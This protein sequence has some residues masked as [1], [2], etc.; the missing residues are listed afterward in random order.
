MKFISKKY[1]FLFLFLN[2]VS[3]I[4]FSQV[5]PG[6]EDDAD[7]VQNQNLEMLS[8]N[9]QSE[10][11]DFT[12]LV[13]QLKYF[14]AHPINLNNTTKDELLSLGLLTELQ[15]ISLLEHIEKNG[16]FMTI[17]ELQSVNG[18]DI[19]TIRKILPFVEVSDNFKSA[20]F[21]FKEMMKNG[22]H[23]VVSRLQR[24]LEDQSG[25]KPRPSDDSINFNT[26][27][28]FYLG[29]AN[30]IFTRY[31]FTYGNNVSLGFIGEKDAGEA[32]RKI[33]ALNKKAGFDFYTAHFF[34]R[35]VKWIKA[36]AVGDYQASFGQGLV[37]W[38]GFGF[39]KNAV[40]TS[41][42][43]NA[44]G[45]NQYN[46]VDENR[47]LRGAA[48]TFNVGK[49]LEATAIFSRKKVDAN[50]TVATDTIGNNLFD[51]E[52]ISS[53]ITGGIHSTVNGLEDKNKITET[54]YGG[55]LTYKGKR[56]NV[57]TTMLS[58][59]LDAEIKKNPSI[60][61]QFD[62][63]GKNNLNAGVDFSYIYRNIN[64]YGEGAVSKNGGKAIV[65][66]ALCAL[67]PRFNFVA[68]YRNFDKDYQNLVA[69]AISENTLPQ[70][71]NGLYMGFEAKLPGNITFTS[72][73]DRFKFPWLKST[74]TGSSDGFDFFSQLNWT[75][76]KKVDMYLR[77]RSRNRQENTS[78]DNVFDYLA[79]YN[80]QNFRYNVTFSVIPS[81]RLRTRIE[82]VRIKKETEKDE[83]GFV[84]FQDVVWKKLGWPL[85]VTA[86]YGIFET[87]SY[88]S[89]IY[90]YENDVLYSFSVPALYNKGQ[91]AYLIINY[92][93]T[94][95][96]EIW[97]RFAQTF[98]TNQNIQSPGD[99]LTEIIGPAKSE[100]KIQLRIKL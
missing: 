85:T 3:T 14:S 49:R 52:E 96:F 81:L 80:Q 17:Y 34:I 11:A 21:G 18:F 30:R 8:E 60:Y 6:K 1:F 92:D 43:R 15:V 25:F 88:T 66:G 16:K 19:P 27:D 46:S 20:H 78:I 40:V 98:Y 55:N 67:D 69:S 74:A 87:D 77:A 13:E 57:G 33:P 90:T 91:R 35:N 48:F 86:R 64:L 82:A 68:Y 39:G 50:V 31:R 59:N 24:I 54:I 84:F 9:L 32:F 7:N 36:L 22:K 75:P 29:S 76:S 56:L 12:N 42:K 5:V 28:S 2:C 95:K 71:E 63:S 53:L 58:Y 73:F 47:F 41:V 38:R 26:P 4:C 100:I 99:R 61:N 70:N 93:I 44:K 10:D 65:A 45:L 79:Q 89:R 23:E 37:L 72:Y 62:F 97:L 94:K 83:T 51:A